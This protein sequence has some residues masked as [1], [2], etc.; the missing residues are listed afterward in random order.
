MHILKYTLQITDVQT[1]FLPLGATPLTV[2]M[3]HGMPQ[4]WAL[5]D[6]A[7]VVTEARLFRVYGTG[8]DI[9]DALTMLYLATVQDANGFVW[10]IFEDL[11][12]KVKTS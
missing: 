1:L 3:Q 4:L 2:Q 11:T 6:P 10:H 5:V 12:P 8:H 9:A 7:S